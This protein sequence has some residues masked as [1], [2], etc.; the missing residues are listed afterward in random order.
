VAN[1]N[2]QDTTRLKQII[3]GNGS[4]LARCL[5][6]QELGNSY[7]KSKQ[8]ELGIIWAEKGLKYALKYGNDSLIW[9]QYDLVGDL[10]DGIFDYDEAIDN[11]LRSLAIKQRAH[12]KLQVANTY[13]DL[14]IAYGESDN[15]VKQT[16]YYQKSQQLFEEL[17]MRD[18]MLN[19]S[20]NLANVY[21][22]QRNFQACISAY[23][24]ILPEVKAK[25]AKMPVT[26]NRAYA[27]MAICFFEMKQPDSTFYYSALAR[28]TAHNSDDLNDLFEAWM[29]Y[30]S[31]CNAF[32]RYDQYKPAIDSAMHY[33]VLLKNR[34]KQSGIY[35]QLAIYQSVVEKNYLEA[36]KNFKKSLEY[37]RN[38]GERQMVISNLG[39]VA[40]AYSNLG[41][42]KNAYLFLGEA[43][44]L[45]D[46]IITE[47]GQGKIAE[48]QTKYQTER[49]EARIEILD[50]ENKLQQ[51]TAYFL[52]G[53]L[54]LL[55]L[56]GFSLFRNNRIKQK[57]NRKLQALNGALDEANQSK[58]KLFSILS[59]DL[60]SPVS[61]LFSYLQLQKIAPHLLTEEKKLAKQEQ[62]YNSTDH[63]LNTM[64]DL[65][66]WSKSQLESFVPDKE[67]LSLKNL[68]ES[69]AGIYTQAI[70]E[71][72]IH[73]SLPAADVTVSSDENMLK[74]ILRNLM[75][76]AVKFTPEWGEIRIEIN[77]EKGKIQL[78]V[79]NS[80][81]P[82]SELVS[83]DLF[84]W[85]NLKSN[86]SG[87]GLKLSKELADK[88]GIR[89]EAVPQ[90]NGNLF[91]L[92]MNA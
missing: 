80:G 7:Y 33:A 18:R 20:G 32:G 69:V 8:Y 43:Y 46:S 64:E 21:K 82:I 30:C 49:K 19:L 89:I 73:L 56:V 63:L 22:R 37:S 34:V 9:S 10:Y 28:I 58:A 71:K 60:R 74:T 83:K 50:K 1:I 27:N 78:S 90:P 44:K 87:Y 4:D 70:A 88:L 38:E 29:R 14:G 11:Y 81:A 84:S 57:N 68:S 35:S 13:T 26:L 42:Y 91:L 66:L 47:A 40:E 79:F 17:G 15:Y 76:N 6:S 5:A 72:S 75:N 25:A 24:K 85:S 3:E 48:M 61:D 62:L 55:A 92:S 53:G 51:R 52:I 65:L 86:Q 12:N 16:E 2:A 36:L 39:D 77:A 23:H 45:K 41:D 67:V 59:H 54:G 31:Y